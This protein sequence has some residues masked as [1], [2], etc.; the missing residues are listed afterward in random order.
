MAHAR[1][2]THLGDDLKRVGRLGQVGVGAAFQSLDPVLAAD[3][4]AGELQDPDG[5]GGGVGLDPA[6]HLEAA[7]IG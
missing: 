1:E 3:E 5:G 6:A 2:G 4:M 7:E